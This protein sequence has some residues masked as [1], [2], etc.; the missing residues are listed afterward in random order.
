MRSFLVIIAVVPFLL[1]PAK[2]AQISLAANQKSEAVILVSSRIMEGDRDI[3]KVNGRSREA[4][5]EKDRR[6]LRESVR[7]LSVYLGKIAGT[8]PVDVISDSKTAPPMKLPVYIGELAAEKFGPVNKSYSGKQAFRYVAGKRGLG[9][10]GESDLAASYAI[11]ELLDKLGCRWFMPGELGECIPA[12]SELRIEEADYA[13]APG[14]LCRE[15][16]L[17]DDAYRRRNRLG[18]ILL[19]TGHALEAY[20]TKADREAHPEYRAT[21]SGVPSEKRLKWSSPAVASA[22]AGKI[23]ERLNKVPQASMSLSPDDGSKFDESEEDR[24]LDAGDFDPTFQ[25]VSLT[26]RLMVLCNRIVGEVVKHHPDTLFGMLAYVQYTRPPV[27]EKLHPNLIPQIAPISYDRAHPIPDERAPNNVEYRKLIEGWGKASPRVSYYLYAYFLGEIS[28]PNPLIRKWSTDLPLFYQNNCTFWQP[29][30]AANFETTMQGLHLGNRLAWDP[31]QD[32]AAIIADLNTRFYGNAS[33]EM[34]AY[35]NYIDSVWVDNPEYTGGD[36]GY[37]LRFTPAVMKMAREL[38]N[39]GVAACRTKVETERV[40]LADASLRQ[41][42]KYMKLREDYAA[43]RFTKL[44]EE[45][46][47]YRQELIALSQKYKENYAFTAAPWAKSSTHALVWHDDFKTISYNDASRIAAEF[48]IVTPE[49][50]HFKFQA[51]KNDTGLKE[52]WGAAGFDDSGW[53]ETNPAVESWSSIGLYD[54]IGTVWYRTK[55]ES[56]GGS[57]KKKVYLWLGGT[58]GSA[59]VYVNGKEVSYINPKTN[60]PQVFK[61]FCRPASFEMTAALAEGRNEIAIRTNRSFLNEI[62]TGGLL[63]PVVIYRER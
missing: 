1:P 2:A 38:M 37:L 33:K 46:E 18:G 43:G 30:T 23:V 57:S 21:I 60:E 63:G 40:E 11:Y 19:Q 36:F 48:E 17:A 3:S 58:D 59:E 51:D 26:D 42:E 62:G 41:F 49:P 9:L 55:V 12:V 31:R 35:W 56:T 45:N 10:Y 13:S 24:R 27:R 4:Q 47:A 44:A 22:I 52:G 39:A 54:H 53:K 6:R 50:I 15:I 61:G 29:E 5:N 14:T 8:Q 7:D 16:W 25:T 34:E 32:P 20:L 28:A